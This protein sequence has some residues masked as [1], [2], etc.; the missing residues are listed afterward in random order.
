VAFNE[1]NALNAH[2]NVR[3]NRDQGDAL[4]AESE[5]KINFVLILLIV[6][7]DNNIITTISHIDQAHEARDETFFYQHACDCFILSYNFVSNKS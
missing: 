2:M 4:F 5:I 1:Q 6:L 7:L 3:Y